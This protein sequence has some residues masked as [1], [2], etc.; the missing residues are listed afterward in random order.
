[1][2]IFELIMTIFEASTIFEAAG[3]VVKISLSLRIKNCIQVKI[4]QI[5][6]THC[7]MII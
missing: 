6:D 4:A 5:L 7:N 2:I 3:A 1:M